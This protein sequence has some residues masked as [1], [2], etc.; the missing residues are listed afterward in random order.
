MF[1]CFVALA[2]VAT[3]SAGPVSI[4]LVTASGPLTVDRSSIWGNATLFEG[5]SVST[6]DASGEVALRNGVRIQLAPSSQ[7]VIGEKHARLERGATQINVGK[8]N[9]SKAY[10]V[11]AHG[12]R[13]AA[14]AGA[15]VVVALDASNR[16]QVS[17][18]SGKASVSDHAGVLLAAI[19]PGRTVAFAMPQNQPAS[20]SVMRN[21]CLLYKDMHFILHDDATNEVVELNGSDLNLNVGKSVQV[22]GN[23]TSVKPA[24]SIATSVM[25]VT[26]VAPRSTGGCLVIAQTLDAQTQVPAAA[27]APTPA[28]PGAAPATPAAPAASTGAGLSSGAKTAIVIVAVAAVGGG[29]GAYFALKGSTSK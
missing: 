26:A 18:L 27:G 22:T 5:T 10:E 25:N 28:T 9:A 13:I 7:A 15:R 23:P 14:D 17:S 29:V 3:L 6:A 11:E 16:V 24:V 20:T 4:G 19:Q 12:L 8:A 21:G 1:R 2:L